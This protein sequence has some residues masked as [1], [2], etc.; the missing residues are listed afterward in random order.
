MA[1]MIAIS[2]PG[3]CTRSWPPEAWTVCRVLSDTILQLNTLV[4][5][6]MIDF[7][8]D[9]RMGFIGI[10]LDHQQQVAFLYIGDR[11]R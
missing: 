7:E 1:L 2:L 4:L 9:H 10:A 3:L 11:S 6:A 8:T 5:H